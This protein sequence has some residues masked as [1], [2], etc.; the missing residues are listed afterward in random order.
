MKIMDSQP[1]F[2]PHSGFISTLQNMRLNLGCHRTDWGLFSKMFSITFSASQKV[3]FA[4]QSLFQN[5]FFPELL[6]PLKDFAIDS[7]HC[8]KWLL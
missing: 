2:S 1:L 6:I 7:T 8:V 4:L 3:N 5:L